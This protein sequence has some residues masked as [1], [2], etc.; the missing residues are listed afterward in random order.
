MTKLASGGTSGSIIEGTGAV[1]HVFLRVELPNSK[2][3]F[4]FWS[5]SLM[6]SAMRSKT[7]DQS[8]KAKFHADTLDTI[9]YRF[10]RVWQLRALLC[11]I[12]GADIWCLNNLRS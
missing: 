7:Q 9:A 12:P 6:A 3:V 11:R 4:G 5:W 1:K 10:Q 2:A 8:P